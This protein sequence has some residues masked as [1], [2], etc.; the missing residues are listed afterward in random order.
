MNIKTLKTTLANVSEIIHVSDVHIRLNSRHDEYRKV[1]ETFYT[2]IQNS[3]KNSIVINTGDTLHAKI[4]LSPEAVQLASD[5]FKRIAEIRPLIVI[6]GNHDALLASLSRMDS[7]TP[8]VSALGSNNIYFLRESGLYGFSDI[9]INNMSVFDTAEKYIDP[10][11]VPEKVKSRY[12]TTL[13]LYHGPLH[14]SVT[15]LGQTMVNEVMS[16]SRFTG[17][18]LALLGDIHL[19]QTFVVDSTQIHY[20]GSLIQQDYGE[21]LDGHG[22]TKW[23]LGKNITHEHIEVENVYGLATITVKDG[24]IVQSPKRFPTDTKLRVFCENTTISTAK[25]IVSDL[26]K[27]VNVLDAV[28]IPVSQEF[29]S[30]ANNCPSVGTGGEI[31]FDRITSKEYQAELIRAYLTSTKNVTDEDTLNKIV[32]LNNSLMEEITVK[33]SSK[34]IVWVPLKFEFSNMF[35]YGENNVVDFSTMRGTYGLFSKN[36]SGK[37]S[38]FQAMCF[39]LFDKSEKAFKAVNLINRKCKK[40][41]CKFTF[42]IHNEI[43]AIERSGER[44]KKGNVKVDVKFY[45][46]TGSGNLSLNAD[47]RRSTNDVIRDYIGSYDDFILTSLVLQNKSESLAD[48]GNTERKDLLCRFV[49]LDIFDELANLALARA[50]PIWAEMQSLGA[51]TTQNGTLH[52]QKEKLQSIID[53]LDE[54]KENENRLLGEIS[55]LQSQIVDE[56]KNLLPVKSGTELDATEITKRI[57]EELAKKEFREV[58]LSKL[59]DD[60]TVADIAALETEKKIEELRAEI[61]GHDLTKLSTKEADAR[62]NLSIIDQRLREQRLSISEKVKKLEQLEKHEYDPNCR[63]CVNSI[64]VKDAIATKEQLKQDEVTVKGLIASR[65]ELTA[66]IAKLAFVPMLQEKKRALKAEVIGVSNKQ[67]LVNAEIERDTA[68]LESISSEIEKLHSY[69]EAVDKEKFAIEKNIATNKKIATYTATLRDKKM[70]QRSTSENIVSLSSQRSVLEERLKVDAD[71]LIKFK[72]LESKYKIYELY[73]SAIDKNGI[74]YQ[75]LTKLIPAIESDANKVLSQMGD[76]TV[77]LEP[78]GKNISIYIKYGPEEKD[79]WLL[80]M[81]SGMEQ[82]VFSIALRIAL[83]NTCNLPRA[84]FLVIDEGFSAID[85]ENATS[86]AMLFGYMKTYFD[87]IIIMSHLES[88]RDMVDKQLEIGNED[89]FSIICC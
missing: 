7:V 69:L 56:S 31:A 16:T 62:W 39:C 75:I 25:K 19:E 49:G 22:F 11:T 60:K 40:F 35:S 63:F 43:Y 5:F 15:A 10:K 71:K 33:N 13:S 76:F 12:N 18:D 61:N 32:F 1:F 53:A 26:G 74:P 52:D 24:A 77:M 68:M 38:I 6:S 65:T 41:S 17:F 67:A 87:F 55:T 20:P 34:G 48:V 29:A 46:Q 73:L 79:R 81:A 83:M 64:F 58:R 84:K 78:D 57:T 72:E 70:Q 2:H 23:K 82:F 89:G 3:D 28:Y 4:N 37:T 30:L 85:S 42:K 86:L 14:G 47:A 66:E 21:P 36:R 9:L 45:K 51:K 50:N 88:M 54:Y 59:R 44:D 80:E 8:I 27:R